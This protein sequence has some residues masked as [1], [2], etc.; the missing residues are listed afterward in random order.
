[1][2]SRDE[3]IRGEMTVRETIARYPQV[4]VVLEKHGLGECGGPSGSP[5]PIAFFAHLH[6]VDADELLRDMNAALQDKTQPTPAR[7]VAQAAPPP[8]DIYRI[9][10]KTALI[11]ALTAGWTLGAVSLSLL[12]WGPG[13]SVNWVGLFQAHGYAQLFGWI[14]LFIMGVAYHV[15]PRLKA[16]ELYSRKLALASYWLM[17]VGLVLRAVGQ[18]F[19]AGVPGGVVL[20]VGAV[21]LLGGASVFVYVLL[22]TI[23]RSPQPRAFF[24]S[25]LLAGAVWF[26]LSTLLGLAGSVEA[27]SLGLAVLSASWNAAFL[28]ASMA[29]FITMFIL[30]ITLRTVPAFLGL[31]AGNQKAFGVIFWVMNAGVALTVGLDLAS[32]ALGFSAS[33]QLLAAG[34]I[35]ELVAAWGF[36]Y[37]LNLF[38]KP[39][40]TFGDASLDRSYEPFIKVAYLWFLYATA[41]P[42]VVAAAQLVGAGSALDFL[43]A[44]YRH[45]LTI[46]FIS[47]MTMGMASRM[48]AVFVGVRLHSPR[49]LYAALVL[50]NVGAIGRVLIQLVPGPFGGTANAMLGASGLVALAG[51]AL[52]VYNIWRTMDVS[53]PQKEVAVE[54]PKQEQAIRDDMPVGEMLHEFPQSLGVLVEHGM[55]RLK[56]PLERGKLDEGLTLAE[57]AR[58]EGLDL[59]ALL[60]DLNHVFGIVRANSNVNGTGR[61][62]GTISGETIVGVLLEQHPELLPVFVRHGFAHL[63]DERMRSTMA[64]T[65]TIAMASQIHGIS[66]PDLLSDLEGALNSGVTG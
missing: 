53:Q 16:T 1:M 54:T 12:A 21:C 64:K 22:R 13:L 34:P 20:V 5:E 11:V 39:A 4:R 52:F 44:S 2:G 27:A 42:A 31:R 25:Y 17:L 60:T 62:T 14:G 23:A 18:P 57:L 38:R 28:H 41:I 33:S 59:S 35:L 30:G 15:L 8:A 3:T 49:L 66:L 40:V 56:D 10:I 65:V 26:W 43:T 37:N 36:V 19:L 61:K 51:L 45:A 50:V 29:G 46:G 32:A 9:F 24:E 7:P 63:Q 6:R 58:K 55:A 47:L 48:V